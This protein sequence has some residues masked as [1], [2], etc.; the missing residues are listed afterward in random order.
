MNK[1][2]D[3]VFSVIDDYTPYLCVMHSDFSGK[4]RKNMIQS[5]P[6][7]FKIKFITVKMIVCKCKDILSL[8]IETEY[9]DY[10]IKT[11]EINIEKYFQTH[12]MLV[13]LKKW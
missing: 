1:M 9:F 10:L 4:Y 5:R 8:F 6:D 7:N 12:V 2:P 11:L 13:N 3:I